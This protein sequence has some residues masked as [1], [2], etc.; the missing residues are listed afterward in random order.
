MNTSIYDIHTHDVRRE[1]SVISVSPDMFTPQPSLYYSVGI[2]P[3]DSL[4][5]TTNDLQSLQNIVIDNQV[6]AI[7]ETGIDR[8]KGAALEQQ[9][10]LLEQ[11]IL[12]SEKHQK[13][14]ILHV[15]RAIDIIIALHRKHKP[16]QQWI[17]HGYRGNEQSAQQLLRENIHLSFGEKFNVKAV[18]ITPLEKLWIESDE[19]PADISSIYSNIAQIKNITM[20]QLKQSI[21]N[22]AEKL[23]FQVE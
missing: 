7:G 18:E 6:V 2:H 23:F 3:W 14:L 20:E 19:S 12:L 13:P 15:V 16:T 5:A 11:H 8:L 10:E 22:R 21:A 1:N 9:I 17:I 4:I